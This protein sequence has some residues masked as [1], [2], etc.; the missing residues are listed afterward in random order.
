MIR[1]R[2]QF[3]LLN[4]VLAWL[5][6]TLGVA[7]FH[8]LTPNAKATEAWRHNAAY[9]AHW[10][11]TCTALIVIFGIALL[12]MLG[13]E[14]AIAFGWEPRSL[15]IY[16]PG[17]QVL[18]F[19]P[20]SPTKS[21]TVIVRHADGRVQS[22]IADREE[23]RQLEVD[24]VAHLWVIGKQISRVLILQRNVA[25]LPPSRAERADVVPDGPIA[26][27]W[28][29]VGI[30]SLISA[31][32]SGTGLLPMITREFVIE[33]GRRRTYVIYVEQ[34]SSVSAWGLVAFLLGVGILIGLAYLWKR[35]WDNEMFESQYDG[36]G[37]FRG[38]RWWF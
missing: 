11:Q 15:E 14:L 29:F 19:Q 21:A 38:R 8:I 20:K 30:L 9:T 37:P 13:I 24:S 17:C 26:N 3:F 23:I 1:A 18:E 4:F 36:V 33:S 34:G 31:Y 12:V 22:Y 6:A 7:I 10:L 2:S 28:L 27:G 16:R 32:L 35:G 5:V 25:T